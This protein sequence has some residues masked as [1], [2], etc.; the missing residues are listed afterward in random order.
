MPVLLEDRH[1]SAESW[2]PV[3]NS[4]EP[5]DNT[6][7]VGDGFALKLT[8]G[9]GIVIALS[10]VGLVFGPTILRKLRLYRAAMVKPKSSKVGPSKGKPTKKQPLVSK[11]AAPVELDDVEEDE[12]EEDEDEDEEDDEDEDDDEEEEEEEDEPDLATKFP[13]GSEAKAVNLKEK[14]YLVHNQKVGV[15]KKVDTRAGK[16]YLEMKSS[17]A[18]LVLREANVV[19]IDHG[20]P[21][22]KRGSSAGRAAAGGGRRKV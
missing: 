18:R 21:S 1:E 7:H 12:D 8:A 4:Q 13:V 6:V 11:R 5:V 17:G 2:K 14:K 16:L 19:P 20:A 3:D 10:V 9:V 22:S 15:I